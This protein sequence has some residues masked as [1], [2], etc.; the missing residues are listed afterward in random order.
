MS[1]RLITIPSNRLVMLISRELGVPADAVAAFV[2][3]LEPKELVMIREYTGKSFAFFGSQT[4]QHVETFKDLGLKFNA[5]LKAGPGW[6]GSLKH[7]E[8]TVEAMRGV[9]YRTVRS[10]AEYE[11]SF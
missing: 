2:D 11:Q 3:S 1:S 7:L 6:V 9:D 5:R 8:K 4:Y 10:V